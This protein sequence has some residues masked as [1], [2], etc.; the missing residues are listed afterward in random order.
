MS[1]ADIMQTIYF[2]SNDNTDIIAN[3]GK[4]SLIYLDFKVFKAEFPF[5]YLNIL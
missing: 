5:V 2:F 1:K 4:I 3:E